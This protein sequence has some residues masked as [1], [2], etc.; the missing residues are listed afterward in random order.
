MVK[1]I[2][3]FAKHNF[4]E[5]IVFGPNSETKRTSNRFRNLTLLNTNDCIKSTVNFLLL[6]RITDNETTGN[7]KV[8]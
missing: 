1:V 8:L 4:K 2:K 7:Y 5:T 3:S 6:Q